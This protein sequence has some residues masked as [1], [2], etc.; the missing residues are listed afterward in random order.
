MKELDLSFEIG[1]KFPAH[2]PLQAFERP[3]AHVII[4]PAAL[5]ALRL[6]PLKVFFYRH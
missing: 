4:T 3:E 2:P 5:V 6:W 1:E